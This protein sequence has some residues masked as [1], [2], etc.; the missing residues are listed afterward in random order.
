MKYAPA[1][2]AVTAELCREGKGAQLRVIN[3]GEPIPEADLP[4]I[5]DRFYR[6]DRARVEGG[7]G[8]GLAIARS[9]SESLGAALSAENGPEGVTFTLRL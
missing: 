4:H 9:L 2:S 6:T 5:F 1:G 8:L 3:G 7:Y